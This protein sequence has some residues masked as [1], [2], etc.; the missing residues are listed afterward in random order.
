M[1]EK[2]HHV[3]KM[4]NIMVNCVCGQGDSPFH[5]VIKEVVDNFSSNK[6]TEQ[7]NNS[8]MALQAANN[9]FSN[10]CKNN[11]QQNV[12]SEN[13][14]TI[15]KLTPGSHFPI[16]QR[17]GNN[18]AQENTAVFNMNK[19]F[20]MRKMGRPKQLLFSNDNKP[21]VTMPEI[22]EIKNVRFHFLFSMI[23]S[24]EICIYFY[25]S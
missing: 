18:K 14:P 1:C 20:L 5:D 19:E 3:R 24:K 25:C 17:H 9:S 15:I 16:N 23:M 11:Q 10:L 2:L 13:E 7:T 4:Y 12:K 6:T 8:I 22:V 21:S